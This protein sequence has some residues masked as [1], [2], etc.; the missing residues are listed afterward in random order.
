[1]HLLALVAILSIQSTPDNSNLLGKSKKVRVIKSSK[2]INRY[3]DGEGM[4]IKQQ[5]IQGWTLNLN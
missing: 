3:K 2:Q 4:A 1:M 5:S